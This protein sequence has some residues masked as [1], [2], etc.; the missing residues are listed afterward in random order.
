MLY[1]YG[2]LYLLSSCNRFLYESLPA[3]QLAHYTCLLEFA[4]EFLQ[5]PL[6][7]LT[8]FNRNYNHLLTTSF[9]YR[10]AKVII[11]S[12]SQNLLQVFFLYKIEFKR[13]LPFYLSAYV[14]YNRFF[15]ID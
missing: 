7:I 9:Y 11:L 2:L 3:S 6:D 12:E 4:F 13:L 1:I 8:L 14:L 10:T 5:S 15:K